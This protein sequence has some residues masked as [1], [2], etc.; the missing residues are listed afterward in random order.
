[1]IEAYLDHLRVERR[2]ADHTLE[3]YARDL[4]GLAA[5]AAGRGARIEALDRAA[6]E[7]FVRQQMARGLS[8]RSVARGVAAVR[9]FYRFLMLDRHIER[10]PADD[11][12]PPR[13]WPALP[14]FLSLEEVDQLIAAPDTSTPI[15]QRDRAMVEP[16]DASGMR[17]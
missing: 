12:R 10:N 13:A 17:V 4:A 15:G 2:L 16:L 14:K 11:L 9:G 1:M 8:P 5:F 7:A 3:S 6:L